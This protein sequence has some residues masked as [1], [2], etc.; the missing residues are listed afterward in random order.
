MADASSI[1]GDARSDPH[2]RSW[3]EAENDLLKYV[4]FLTQVPEIVLDDELNPVRNLPLLSDEPNSSFSVRQNILKGEAGQSQVLKVFKRSLSSKGVASPNDPPLGDLQKQINFLS[5]S[6][7][8]SHENL[9]TLERITWGVHSHE[10]L[11]IRPILVM[12]RAMFGNL[13]EFQDCV[14]DVSWTTRKALCYDICSGLEFLHAHG[15]AHG[16]LNPS[17][18]LISRHGE[19]EYL[20]KLTGFSKSVVISSSN[21]PR[22]VSVRPYSEPWCALET[23]REELRT[24]W[25]FLAD[26]FPLGLLM[27]KI[28]VHKDPFS[29][30]DLT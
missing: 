3:Q 1:G 30:F 16:D 10:P 9:T 29:A 22:K 4:T 21:R 11:E 13:D 27:W 15:I 18:V 24:D 25:I 20:A 7:V 17:H 2:A 19:R 6:A 26:I 14:K 23:R 8:V 28:F 12:E 5:C